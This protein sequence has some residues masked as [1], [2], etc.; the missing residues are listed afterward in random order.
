MA[1]GEMA[2]GS[3]SFGSLSPALPGSSFNLPQG[4]EDLGDNVWVSLELV[5]GQGASEFLWLRQEAR[6][7]RPGQARSRQREDSAQ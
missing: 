1:P 3:K 2:T 5:H 4:Y 6:A 7:P